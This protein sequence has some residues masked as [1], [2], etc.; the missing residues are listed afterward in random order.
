M[1]IQIFTLAKTNRNWGKRTAI[2]GVKKIDAGRKR[3][4][5]AAARPTSKL[6]IGPVKATMSTPALGPTRIFQGSGLTGLP[7]PKPT[8][9]GGLKNSSNNKKGSTRLKYLPR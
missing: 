3:T 4:M 9:N 1:A 5:L 6:K 8:P 2:V 7:Q